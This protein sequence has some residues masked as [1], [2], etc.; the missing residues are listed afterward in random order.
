M[1]W[2]GLWHQIEDESQKKVEHILEHLFHAA[3]Q[4]DIYFDIHE[5]RGKDLHLQLQAKQFFPWEPVN[6]I[7]RLLRSQV[8]FY[9]S[10]FKHS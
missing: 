4:Q 3:L 1:N 2:V 9:E 8:K 5:V 10:K 7:T 6:F